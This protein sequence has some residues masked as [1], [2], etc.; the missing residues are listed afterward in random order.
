LPEELSDHGTIL[1]ELA[2]K[3]RRTKSEFRFLNH[4]ARHEDFPKLV[5]AW[6]IQT[7]GT[8]M[9]K[10]LSR[11]KKTRHELQLWSKEV[12]GNT[13]KKIDRCRNELVAV[14]TRCSNDS[15]EFQLIEKEKGLRLE[16]Q[17]LLAI[18]ESE[19]RQRSRIRWLNEGDGNNKFFREEKLEFY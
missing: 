16:L 2:P 11:L 12:F 15:P 18:E 8:P 5:N 13:S 19:L 3:Q 9:L 1:V 7:S 10:L 6:K 17:R 14:Q 4:W